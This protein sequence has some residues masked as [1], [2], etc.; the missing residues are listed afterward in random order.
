MI[1]RSLSTRRINASYRDSC[2]N[3]GRRFDHGARPGRITASADTAGVAF[4]T[5]HVA[6]GGEIG[7]L[8]THSWHSYNGSKTVYAHG[9][10]SRTSKLSKVSGYLTDSRS[11]EYYH[12][13]VYLRWTQTGQS[14]YDYEALVNPYH[15]R[16]VSF[17]ATY[18]SKR[19]SH[20]YVSEAYAKKVDG[21]WTVVKA[22]KLH[23]IY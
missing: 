14:G 4:G 7:T 17:P 22:G 11:G 8:A 1:V 9:S 3:G 2:R 15:H 10:Y 18:T 23:K 6:T 13:A 5:A 20:L 19:T 16:T 12:A 21:K